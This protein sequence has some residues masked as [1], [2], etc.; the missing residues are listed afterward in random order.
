MVELEYLMDGLVMVKKMG[1]RLSKMG[2]VMQDAILNCWNWRSI[3]WEVAI[4]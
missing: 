2:H 4:G 1:S 3:D